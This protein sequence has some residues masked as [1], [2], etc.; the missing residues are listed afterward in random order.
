MPTRAN[1]VGAAVQQIAERTRTLARLEAEL[2]TL[3]LRRKAAALGGGVA[4]LAAAAVVVL[5]G[6]G[7]L[8]ATAAAA[9]A[10][11]LPTWAA[12]M[13]VAAVLVLVAVILAVAGRSLLRRAV[14]PVPEQ[15][16]AEAR[17]TGEA[18]RRNGGA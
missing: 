11:F 12:L 15:A 5:F 3:E 14:P 8:L 6:I 2:A 17:R 7:F 1:G 10:T 18:L 4:L 16:V 9:L 13:I